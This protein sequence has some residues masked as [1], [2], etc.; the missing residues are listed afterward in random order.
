MQL[1]KD[2]SK[3][4]ETLDSFLKEHGFE[5]DKFDID[6]HSDGHFTLASYKNESK[7]FI[8]DYRFSIGQVLYQYDNSI[9]SHPFY[10]RHLG[11]ADQK[12]H[13]T[14]LS[15]NNPQAFKNIL[16]DFKYLTNDFFTG[17]CKKL[18]EISELQDNIIVEFDK[19][20]RK[21]NNLRLD[22]IRIEKARKE[23]RNKQYI[24]CLDIYRFIDNKY[25]LME[26]DH[27]IMEFCERN[28]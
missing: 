5:L 9:V 23:F 28:L 11:F 19:K 26:L 25:L 14:F 2:L 21:E 20:I 27:R 10:L 17:D 6:K 1:I 22:S 4:L 16:H 7:R 18:K 8:I 12:K 15:D 3:G 24:Q 13:K